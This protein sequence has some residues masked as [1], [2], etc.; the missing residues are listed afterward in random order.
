MRNEKQLDNQEA[1]EKYTLQ[2]KWRRRL[3]VSLIHKQEKIILLASILQDIIAKV[4]ITWELRMHGEKV[5][6]DNKH[7]LE[8]IRIMYMQMS[9]I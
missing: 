5:T 9:N 2:R 8:S 1:K 7:M 3:S 4:P 6:K